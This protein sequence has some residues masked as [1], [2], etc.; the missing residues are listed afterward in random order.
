M[1]R[2][3]ELLDIAHPYRYV[4]QVNTERE[5]HLT[6]QTQDG[7]SVTALLHEGEPHEA[8]AVHK[9]ETLDLKALR[10]Y[11]DRA[12]DASKLALFRDIQMNVVLR[13]EDELCVIIVEAMLAMG[14]PDEAVRIESM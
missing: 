8:F 14:L 2:R 9:N 13:S 11:L 10:S 5:Q 4:Q 6:V 12:P 1:A 7:L 3:V